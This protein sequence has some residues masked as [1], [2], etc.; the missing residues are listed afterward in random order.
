VVSIIT[1]YYHIDPL[2]PLCLAGFLLLGAGLLVI[3]YLYDRATMRTDKQQAQAAIERLRSRINSLTTLNQ[4]VINMAIINTQEYFTAVFNAESTREVEFNAEWNNGTG[5]FDALVN[6]AFPDMKVGTIAKTVTPVG[7][8]RRILIVKTCFGNVVIF[9]RY[10]DN[11]LKGDDATFT[12]NC[13]RE[14]EKLA[15]ISGSRLNENDMRYLVGEPEFSSIYPNIGETIEGFKHMF[16][17]QY[18]AKRA[19]YIAE[20]SLNVP[21]Q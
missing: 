6:E 1:W 11:A 2:A 12:Y 3:P 21:A 16:T 17:E 9:D 13:P 14:V 20:T 10:S 5:Y 4:L 19:R 8:D 18:L 7:N 15:R